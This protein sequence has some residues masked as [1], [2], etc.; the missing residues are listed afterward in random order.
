MGGRE[1]GHA[2]ISLSNLSTLAL[3]R[4]I[5]FPLSPI[6]TFGNFLINYSAAKYKFPHFLPHTPK[7]D[8]IIQNTDDQPAGTGALHGRTQLFIVP[9]EWWLWAWELVKDVFCSLPQNKM[10]C[11]HFLLIIIVS[12]ILWSRNPFGNYSTLTQPGEEGTD[13]SYLV[14]PGRDLPPDVLLLLL[15]LLNCDFR[16]GSGVE[17]ETNVL[18]PAYSSS[19]SSSSMPSICG[20][21]SSLFVG[22]REGNRSA[23]WKYIN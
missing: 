3:K 10:L 19:A 2:P 20:T 8:D 21:L 18:W 5:F 12:A 14:G 15:L 17:M 4:Y 1:F 16:T 22:T 9:S 11:P 13:R 7:D 23:R 6:D